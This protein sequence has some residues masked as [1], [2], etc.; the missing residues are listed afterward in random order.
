MQRAYDQVIHD[1]ALQKPSRRVLSS[2]EADWLAADGATHHGF[3]DI[4]FMRSIPNMIV[5]APMDEA[6]LRNMLY[7][8]QLDK[9]SSPYR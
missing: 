1:V 4:A 8:A 6:D 5:A 3:F 2:T 7:T 9:I